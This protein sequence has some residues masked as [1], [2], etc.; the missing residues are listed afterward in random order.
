MAKGSGL[1]THLYQLLRLVIKSLFRE[2]PRMLPHEFLGR[3]RNWYL[4][5]IFSLYK[6]SFI[7]ERRHFCK[8]VIWALNGDYNNNYSY[9]P[10]PSRL[11]ASLVCSS[12]LSKFI[13]SPSASDLC[14]YNVYL[15]LTSVK[16][17]PRYEEVIIKSTNDTTNKLKYFKLNGSSRSS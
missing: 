9:V 14:P 1:K 5:F 8:F 15:F 12:I 7:H 6:E 2:H 3:I 10:S 13:I 17:Q 16:W 4:F 11:G